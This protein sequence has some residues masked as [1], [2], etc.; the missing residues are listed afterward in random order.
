MKKYTDAAL[1]QKIIEL[2]RAIQDWA[3]KKEIW[4]DSCFKPFLKHV[5]GEPHRDCPVVT[6][7]CAGSGLC[8]LLDGSCYGEWESE[9]IELVGSL[10]YGHEN[11]NGVNFHF[12]PTD[13]ELISAFGEYF[14]WQWVCSLIQ[15]D[16][17]DVYEE[18]YDYFSKSPDRLQSLEWRDYEIL[19]YRIFQQQGFQAE[20]GP[21]SGD[22]GIDIRLLQR[23]PLGDILTLVQAKK[24]KPKNKIKL[25]AVAALH[26]IAK[27]NNADETMFVTTSK[28]APVAKKFAA[29]DTVQMQLKT[30]DDVA[31]W[32]KTATEGIIA[33]KSS[34]IT[35]ESV[36]KI[37][38]QIGSRRDR[39]VLQTSFGHNMTINSFALVLKETQHAALL[40]SLPR[41][42]ITNDH[43]QIGTEIPVVGP[44]ALSMH[45]A[46]TVWRAKRK[47]ENGRVTYW[48]GEHLFSPW[49][50]TPKYFNYMD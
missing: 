17:G 31:I 50:G 43:G 39:R 34:L 7:L 4:F 25:E 24:Y 13:E 32:C 11:I 16:F 46:K 9:F 35:R 40:M 38:Q 5:N 22:G 30:S 6:V 49:D 37:I 47:A 14:H 33:D 2:E 8:D 44:E 19:L 26:G 36:S 12:Y 10:G 1:E 41:R 3:E 29:R 23:D 45:Q 20:L 21:G 48:D 42:N 27:A 28:Y 18:L 15:P